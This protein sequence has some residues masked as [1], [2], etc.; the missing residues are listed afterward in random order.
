M[1]IVAFLGNP[2]RKYARTRH[3]I[4]FILGEHLASEKGINPKQKQFK[5]LTG[6]GKIGGKEVLFLF[7]QTFMNN[8]GESL[9][10]ACSFYK[11]EA[12]H[13]IACHD[14]IEYAFGRVEM[15]FGGGHRGHN[16]IRSIIQHVGSPDFYRLRFGVGRPENPELS[17]ADYVLGKFLGEEEKQIDELLPECFSLIEE[18]V[19]SME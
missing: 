19:S 4:G 8:S 5:A 3:N 6:K 1:I 12:S 10:G 7:P 2:G 15:K 9:L 11:T 18:A 13:I 14:E 17:V 16:G